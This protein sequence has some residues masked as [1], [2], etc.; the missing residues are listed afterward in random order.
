MGILLCFARSGGTLVNRLLGASPHVV[1]LSEVAPR[2]SVRD[3][4]E[5]AVEWLDLV[6]ASEV[7]AVQRQPWAERIALVAARAEARGDHLVVREFVTPS[8]LPGAFADVVPSG[9]L[10]GWEALTAVGV[11]ARPA[12]VVRRAAGA[13]A[14]IVSSFPH[15]A[16]LTVDRFAVAYH[17]YA[18]AVAGLPFVRYEDLVAAPAAALASLCDA[19]ECPFDAE[20]IERF[21]SFDRCTGDLALANPS[22]GST[23]DR[24]EVLD[25]RADDPAFGPASAHPLCRLADDAFGYA[26]IGDTAPAV[27]AIGAYAAEL[28]AARRLLADRATADDELARLS[29]DVA[30]SV[31][32]GDA[33]VAD[34]RS[35]QCD[36][37]RL[38]DELDAMSGALARA[39]G[40]A[41]ERKRQ[42]A[43]LLAELDQRNEPWPA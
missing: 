19:L 37:A 2:A 1:V 4:L 7:D 28:A 11:D 20:A 23:L 16:D 17:G 22:R 12:V 10:D 3:P 27:S 43:L 24:I 25:D 36:I 21:A 32:R 38:H 8:F 31:A 42:V 18:T 13:Y 26:P 39:E 40:A 5:Q 14:S 15:L 33:L 30:A 9:R 35:L 6:G 34:A 41:A 29:A